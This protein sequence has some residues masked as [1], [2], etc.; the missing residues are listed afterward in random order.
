M[1]GYQYGCNGKPRPAPGA[2]VVVQDGY[3]GAMRSLPLYRTVASPFDASVCRYD[4]KTGDPACTG[5]PHR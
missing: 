3:I 1:S 5:C 4:K 2:P